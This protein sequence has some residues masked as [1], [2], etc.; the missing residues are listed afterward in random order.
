MRRR[1]R[2]AARL[3]GGAV[4]LPATGLLFLLGLPLRAL[5]PRRH[6]AYRRWVFRWSCRR[7]LGLVGARVEVHGPLPAPPFLFVSNHISYLDVLVLGSRLPYVFLSKAEVARWPGLGP[8]CRAAGTLF[9]DR[10]ARRDIPVILAQIEAVL[11]RGEGVIFFP[12]ATSSPGADLL[13]FRSPLLALPARKSYPVHY[14]ALHYATPPGSP[15][16]QQAVAWAG[17]IPLV[18]H[19][20]ELLQ[21]PG[22]AARLDLG[23][24]PLVESDRKLLAEKLRDAIAGL[25]TPLA[26]EPGEAGR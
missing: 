26:G 9:I 2:L 10:A 18:P 12:E 20:V 24:E 11:D 25:F 3:A 23:A 1:L 17:S 8:L 14:G 5:A 22:I 7:L 21:L 4:I 13:P 16:A 19:I 15:P 6:P